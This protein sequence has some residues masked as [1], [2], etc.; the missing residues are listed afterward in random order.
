MIRENQKCFNKLLVVVDALVIFFSIN[1]AWHIRF[2]SG[3][4]HRSEVVYPLSVYVT[5]LV[6]MIPV[7]IVIFG[8]GG[9]YS[10]KRFKSIRNE[11]FDILKCNV[12]GILIFIMVLYL[13]KEINYS[14]YMI[15]M[16]F[17]TNVF[18]VSFER[19]LLRICLRTARKRGYNVKHIILVGIS[20]AAVRFMNSVEKKRYWGYSI[21]AI[22]YD[23]ESEKSLSEIACSY[24]KRIGRLYDVN[25]FER[26]IISSNIDEV[27]ITLPFNQYDKMGYIIKLCEKFGIKAQIIPDFSRFLSQRPYFE[28]IDGLPAIG[29][30]YVPLDSFTNK[31]FKRLFD[32]VVSIIA[33]VIL[34]PI[35]I[36]TAVI[37]K[38]TS[39]GPVIFSQKRVGHNKKV[40]TMY[41]FRS[42]KLQKENE[43]KFKW[44]TENDPRKTAFGA[45]L[46]K[47][48]IDELPQLFNVLKGEMSLIGPRPERPYFVDKF[49]E[50]IPKYMVKHQV[51]P[52]ITGWAQVN[53]WRGDTSIEKRIQYDVYYIENW[54][55]I[56][57]LKVMFL[58]VFKGFVNKN[59]Y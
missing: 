35:M 48:S 2:N 5:P 58:T 49:K 25:S 37:I 11:I 6:L 45:F 3:L 36:L 47:T 39:P 50:Q 17:I 19:I 56:L 57:D 29:I 43:E 31:F 13:I 28:E 20:D 12:I 7:Y 40:F 53:G 32:V 27:F 16:F 14:R 26:F 54:S 59:A 55:M 44:T 52:G 30:R 42:M 46:R 18:I 15:F 8:L 1:V 21:D 38:I 24:D 34:S 51:K 33:L 22:F 23:K 41:K 4:I 9:L 10:S